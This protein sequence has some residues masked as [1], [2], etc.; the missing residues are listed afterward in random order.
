MVWSWLVRGPWS[1]AWFWFVQLL[2]WW[3]AANPTKEVEFAKEVIFE[4]SE[5]RQKV[6]ED[7]KR[8]N[9]YL[10]KY[11]LWFRPQIDIKGVVLDVHWLAIKVLWFFI[12]L[13]F[14]GRGGDKIVGTILS[15]GVTGVTRLYSPQC[16][17]TGFKP[18]LVCFP[19]KMLR[20]VG[21][22]LMKSQEK[23]S[24]VLI[25][26]T[27]RK[28]CIQD[29]TVCNAQLS[30]HIDTISTLLRSPTTSKRMT[31]IW[32]YLTAVGSHTEHRRLASQDLQ[33][34]EA[35][36]MYSHTDMDEI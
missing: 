16:R 7:V 28:I 15:N 11:W 17:H 8:R 20:R 35:L 6:F 26:I 21:F 13:W 1:V 29:K 24:F 4:K 33:L 5:L 32:E 36:G 31:T 25:K 3:A 30:E 10:R 18:S 34:I 9:L 22:S 14:S 23:K 2:L 12:C 19:H 27:S